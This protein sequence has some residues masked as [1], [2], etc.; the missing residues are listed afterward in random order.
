MC[1]VMQVCS[2]FKYQFLEC[3]NYGRIRL[4]GKVLVA[5]VVVTVFNHTLSL[6]SYINFGD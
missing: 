4:P 5:A 1:P 3:P 6:Q 2:V